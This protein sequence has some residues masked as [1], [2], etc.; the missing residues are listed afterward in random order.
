LS[1]PLRY[2][3]YDCPFGIF[4]LF[5]RLLHKGKLVTSI[6]CKLFVIGRSRSSV[7]IIWLRFSRLL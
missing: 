6:Y 3:D 1:V 5:L 4:K 7:S 2:T